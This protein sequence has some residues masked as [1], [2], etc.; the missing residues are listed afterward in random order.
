MLF[1][2]PGAVLRRWPRLGSNPPVVHV[3]LREQ[4]R[5]FRDY[6]YAGD[7]GRGGLRLYRSW[8][9]KEICTSGCTGASGRSSACKASSS[10]YRVNSVALTVARNPLSELNVALTAEAS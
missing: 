4:L 2:A 8:E 10:S 6:R 5:K 7:D 3:Q 9:I 1:P